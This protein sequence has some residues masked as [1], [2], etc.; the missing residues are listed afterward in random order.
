MEN[1]NDFQECCLKLKNEFK[2][3]TGN[4]RNQDIGSAQSSQV[5]PVCPVEFA[6]PTMSTAMPM[7]IYQ[8]FITPQNI[9]TPILP[10]QDLAD[11][12]KLTENELRVMMRESLQNPEFLDLVIRLDK[13]IEDF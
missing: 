9:Q 2:L 6:Y 3:A 4:S 13:I 10:P 11:L 12:K 1:E 7:N 5:M 8:P